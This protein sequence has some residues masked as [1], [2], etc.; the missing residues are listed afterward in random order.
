M[1]QKCGWV[2]YR[3]IGNFA[4]RPCFYGSLEDR[5]SNPPPPPY[6]LL[7]I[8]EIPAFITEFTIYVYIC[9]SV[10][11]TR[12][13]YSSALCTTRPYR[14]RE[15][16]NVNVWRNVSRCAVVYKRCKQRLYTCDRVAAFLTCHPSWI[17]TLRLAGHES[18]QADE[19]SGIRFFP[20]PVGLLLCSRSTHSTEIISLNSRTCLQTVQKF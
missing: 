12:C 11:W 18:Q 3:P 7:R 14:L 2:V 5:Q 19:P 13:R 1:L 4:K 10:L 20:A 15:R 17:I 8:L 6:P 9:D 16:K